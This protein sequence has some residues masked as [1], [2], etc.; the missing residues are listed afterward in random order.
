MAKDD[1]G[2][3]VIDDAKLRKQLEQ[4]MR[5]NPAVTTK[6]V[7]GCLLDLAGRSAKMAPVESGDLR[8]DCT[9]KL[10]GVTVFAEQQATGIRAPRTLQAFGTVGYSLPY[11]LRQH[12]E[13]NYR[14]DRTD[15]YVVRSGKN[16]GK[17]VNMVAGGEAKFLEKPFNARLAR[18]IE[19][20]EKIPEEALN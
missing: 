9:A 3:I 15:G 6:V 4:A 20:L 10:N 12:E 17:T 19:V 1:F 14:H 8:N 5:R 16:K 11:A 13:L 7:R 2:G 18:Y